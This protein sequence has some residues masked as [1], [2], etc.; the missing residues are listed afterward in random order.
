MIISRRILD[1][2]CYTCDRSESYPGK[3]EQE[4]WRKA[5][6]DGWWKLKKDKKLVDIQCKACRKFTVAFNKALD[7]MEF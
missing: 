2:H 6:K 7:R 1:L 3:N 4:S 5:N